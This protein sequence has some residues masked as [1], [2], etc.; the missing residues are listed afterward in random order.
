MAKRVSNT[1][2]VLL[3]PRTREAGQFRHIT[4]FKPGVLVPLYSNPLIL[5]GDTWQL[6]C[7]AMVKSI[8]MVVPIIASL[9]FCCYAFFV[10]HRIVNNDFRAF[11]GERDASQWNVAYTQKLPYIQWKGDTTSGTP[12]TTGHAVGH[13]LGLPYIN[14]TSVRIYLTAAHELR[15]YCAVWNEYFRNEGLQAL[16]VFVKNGGNSGADTGVTANVAFGECLPVNRAGDFLAG[17]TKAPQAGPG[18]TLPLSG[19]IPVVTNSTSHVPSYPAGSSTGIYWS[20]PGSTSAVVGTLGSA[21]STG[22]G[23]LANTTAATGSTYAPSNLWADASTGVTMTLNDLRK[24]AAI[25]QYQET[26]ARAG[27]KY[28]EMSESMFGV[29]ASDAR[30][31]LPEFIGGFEEPLNINTVTATANGT[32]QSGDDVYLGQETGKS[33][34]FFNRDLMSYTASEHGTILVVGFIR[35]GRHLYGNRIDRHLLMGELFE[36]YFDMFSGTGDVP[37]YTVEAYFD[38][39]GTTTGVSSLGG[40][41]GASNVQAVRDSLTPLGYNEYGYQ[42]RFGQLNRVSGLFNPYLPAG[43][44]LGIWTMA[45]KYSSAPTLGPTFVQEDAAAIDRA[46]SL[47]ASSTSG[48]TIPAGAYPWWIDF[49]L[50][51]IS[52]RVMRPKNIPGLTRI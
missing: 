14:N 39:N 48:T 51:Y 46:M 16:Q 10:P 19:L 6:D 28:Y 35:Q 38:P 17:L 12:L 43:A 52:T 42:Y 20:A 18:V 29:R 34:T 44:N 32:T 7:K 5:P 11:Y 30:L 27:N 3:R 49:K 25:Q 45:T 22:L 26:L 50:D 23:K 33:T 8:P 9:T 37:V 1:Q 15:A 13:Y 4:T 24:A 31:D 40:W 21:S 47:Q 41:S 36:E 2:S